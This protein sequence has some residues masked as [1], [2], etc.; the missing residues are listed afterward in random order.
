MARSVL[1]LV[2]LVAASSVIAQEPRTHISHSASL[3]NNPSTVAIVLQSLAALGLPS[4]RSL[5]TI[6]Q[7][8][9][10]DSKGKAS[11]LTIE[12]AGVDRIRFNV[13]SDYSYVSNAGSGFVIKQEKRHSLA[14][15][16]TKYRRPD[17]LPSLSLIADYQNPNF[18]VQ[19]VGME[20]VNGSPAHHLS[21]SMSPTDTTPS[22]IEALI[23]EFHVW[24]D[25]ASSLVVKTR[26]FDFSPDTPQNRTA[27]DT[28][29]GNYQRQQGALIPFHVTSYIAG[30]KD[31]DIVLTSINLN[32]S[33]PDSDFR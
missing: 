8:T 18:H 5:Q 6:A 3:S 26:T 20:T 17:H 28:Y 32:A 23:S 25:Q 33:V 13:G 2:V 15:W 27:V 14:A 7:G 9:L 16:S 24:I 19:Y 10:T 4:S 29:L 30:H 31:S 1:S 22:E 21:L 11:P 12:T